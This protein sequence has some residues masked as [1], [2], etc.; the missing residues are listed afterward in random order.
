MQNAKFH[1]KAHDMAWLDLEIDLLA[2][3]VDITILDVLK[4][5]VAQRD[6]SKAQ[7]ISEGQFIYMYHREH[8]GTLE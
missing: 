6:D 8:A 4:Y 5:K 7:T 1:N 3:Y 2:L